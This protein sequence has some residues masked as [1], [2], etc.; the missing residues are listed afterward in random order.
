[1]SVSTYVDYIQLPLIVSELDFQ[2][3]TLLDIQTRAADLQA[4]AAA[5]QALE[6]NKAERGE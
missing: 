3:S 4:S 1:M 6:M 2:I 5:L